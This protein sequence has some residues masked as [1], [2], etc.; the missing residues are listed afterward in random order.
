MKSVPNKIK[1]IMLHV[2]ICCIHCIKV[3]QT[4]KTIK[5]NFSFNYKIGK[6]KSHKIQN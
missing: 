6:H 5:N 1:K 2:K 3:T 4:T